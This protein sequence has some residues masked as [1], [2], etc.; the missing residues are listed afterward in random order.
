MRYGS[1]SMI[2]MAVCPFN[3]RRAL[4]GKRLPLSPFLICGELCALLFLAECVKPEACSLYLH[5]DPTPR[6]D[7]KSSITMKAGFLCKNKS[8]WKA[9]EGELSQAVNSKTTEVG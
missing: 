7:T 4:K 2:S 8:T 6:K 5:F 3:S 1:L 9:A